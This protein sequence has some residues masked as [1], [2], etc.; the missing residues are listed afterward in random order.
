MIKKLTIKNY[1]SH[2]DTEIEFSP[3]VNVFIGESDNGKSSIIRCLRWV[4]DNRPIGNNMRS[5]W[6]GDTSVT[7]D[8][9]TPEHNIEVRRVKTGQINAYSYTVDQ[10]KND[11]FALG[12][13]GAPV[14][15]S[16]LLNIDPV[17]VQYQRDPLFMLSLSAG[18]AAQYLNDVAKL[19]IIDSTI[20]NI[21]SKITTAT[22]E[23]EHSQREERILTAQLHTLDNLDEME[24]DVAAIEH[25]Q[26]IND[27]YHDDVDRIQTILDDIYA[28]N[29]EITEHPKDL[30][31]ANRLIQRA[32]KKVAEHEKAVQ[33]FQ[34][35][36][37][38]LDEISE[39]ETVIHNTEAA[40]SKLETWWHDNAPDICP[41]CGADDFK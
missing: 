7:L 11:L 26:K 31:L 2:K 41:L 6:G 25:L 34:Y 32:S 10:H 9:S 22:S 16:A 18:A 27:D 19:E 14:E 12:T 8:L 38:L 21:K 36:S 24:N 4:F 1:E 37:S 20:D 15:I 23:L 3:F 30:H 28:L 5:R 35:I 29:H 33:K 40:L 39:H 13:G 17:N